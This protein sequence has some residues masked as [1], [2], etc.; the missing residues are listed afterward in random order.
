MATIT[1]FPMVEG[2]HGTSSTNPGDPTRSLVAGAALTPAAGLPPSKLIM[3]ESLG[4][5]E[6]PLMSTQLH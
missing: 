4:T 3:L 1:A 2:G 6:T 5:K